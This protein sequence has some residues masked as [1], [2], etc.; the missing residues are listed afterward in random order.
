MK[1]F[2]LVILIM[3]VFS[4]CNSQIDSSSKFNSLLK[5]TS[6]T[7]VHKKWFSRF[8]LFKKRKSQI[9]SIVS[10]KD[11]TNSQSAMKVDTNSSSKRQSLNK[12]TIV[13]GGNLEVPEFPSHLKSNQMSDWN[14]V[15]TNLKS[16][17][18][19]NIWQSSNV[20]I[21]IMSNGVINPNPSQTITPNLGLQVEKKKGLFSSID[22]DKIVPLITLIL[23]TVPIILTSL[24]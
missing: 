6:D 23:A 11:T 16:P 21:Y 15:D 19:I 3:M 9:K 24:K 13:K 12:D 10:K 20:Q 18:N 14:R 5:F 1:T 2:K 7:T 17:I 22:P 8:K 4:I